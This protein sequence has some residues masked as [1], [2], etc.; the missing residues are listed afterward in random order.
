MIFSVFSF[1][2]EGTETF[3]D[4]EESFETRL[5]V[6]KR[7][8][9]A[10]RL[11]DDSR[12]TVRE[13][14][15]SYLL[16]D[17][18]CEGK[19]L[20]ENKGAVIETLSNRNYVSLQ[21][22][23]FDT[24]SG[25]PE[26]PEEMEIEEYPSDERGYY[27]LQFIGPIKDE[28]K[29][30][31]EDTGVDLHGFRHRFNFIVEMDSE[32]KR[33]A[34][35]L[36]FVNWIGIYQPAYRIDQELLKRSGRLELEVHTFEGVNLMRAGDKIADLGADIHLI[37]KNKISLEIESEKI[38]DLA[39]LP[40]VKSIREEVKDYRL[41][42][43][44]TTWITQTNE[45]D[46]RKVT[47]EGV[48]GEGELITVMDSELYMENSGHQMW[49][50]PD[51]NEV[52][53]EHR[54]VQGFYVPTGSDADLGEGEYHGTHVTGSVLGDAYLY[55]E[56]DENDG[57][58]IGARLIFQDIGTENEEL[59]LPPDM[60]ADAYG[61]SYEEGSRVHT[62]S[63]GGESGY[64]D[65]AATADEFIWNNKNFTIL[66]AMGNEGDEENSLTAQAEGKN[67]ISV[68]GA[69]NAPDQ[70][71]VAEFSG[72]GYADDGRIKPTLL[73]IGQWVTSAGRSKDG[74]KTLSGTSS[75]TPGI[76]GQVGQIRQ[77][78]S[79]G[80]YP[81]GSP[82]TEDGFNP[83]N[84]LV[85]ATLINGAVEISGNGAYEN[86][87]RFP[88]NDQGFGRS[89]LD[90]ALHFEGD[91]RGLEVFDSWNENLELKTG[92]SWETDLHVDDP[93]QELEITLVWSDYPG[94]GDNGPLTPFEDDPAIVNDLDLEV[95][96]PDGTRYAGNAFTGF[97]PGYSEPDPN[98]NPWNGLRD[99]EYDGLNVE[100][101]LLLLPDENGVEI[102][103]YEINVTAH[104]IPE[105]N[106]PFALVVSG[107]MTGQG[108]FSPTKPSPEDGETGVSTDVNLSVH[109][110]HTEDEIMDVRFYNAND[111]EL[112]GERN[113]VE[114][115]ERT[116]VKWTDLETA[117]TYQWYAVAE[118][119][120]GNT[121]KSKTWKFMTEIVDQP[122]FLVNVTSPEDGSEFTESEMINVEYKVE[123]IGDTEGEQDIRFTVH[124]EVTDEKIYED[125]YDDLYLESEETQTGNFTWNPGE[126]GGGEYELRVESENTSDSITITTVKELVDFFEVEIT[127]P[128][129]GD[130]FEKGDEVTV[131]FS[132]TNTGDK[133]G[134]QTIVF[135]VDGDEVDTVEM[136]IEVNET[137]KEEFIW[138]AEESGEFDLKV[139][140]EDDEDAITVTVE[141][142]GGYI[143]DEILEI[144]GFTTTILLFS[145]V[146]AVAIYQKK[147]EER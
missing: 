136:T 119:L 101:N 130:K 100:E 66:Y 52:G 120:D 17:T 70:E 26:V 48:T 146:L 25:V 18:T 8:I 106:Q 82:A 32:T 131:E 141:G 135:T 15:D 88:N 35:D 33:D 45:T 2:G 4:E 91:E 29:E 49:E 37:G 13:E 81:T 54:K 99:E 112:I 31:L 42:N 63:W 115:E 80:W 16:L 11:Q 6:R 114:S 85:R 10:I 147:V 56:Y 110:E 28:W 86:D 24:E 105:G 122:Y 44:D 30:Q 23:S 51:G 145:M 134:T 92:E 43:D 60:Y 62:N 19:E 121:A 53:D 139:A 71:E 59:S 47:E 108:P 9:D 1:V 22:Y 68:G 143:I 36:H 38:D 129:D 87:A 132:I 95:T 83:S 117:M 97:N 140:S 128:Y 137:E 61:R 116:E 39:N 64:G 78:Y 20:L 73:H 89:K 74:Y 69:I 125:I 65:D 40:G 104:N 133:E 144:P 75:A 55:D 127:S 138:T 5:L 96:A 72:R 118:D 3:E 46:N 7:G 21:S 124:E 12:Y 14:Y 50:D 76:A 107:G 94:E 27:I 98:S 93:D 123:N 79:D 111:D 102:G 126:K 77:Y 58:A 34:E 57:N 90:R 113:D 142:E 41:F 67:V 103:T 109:V 84:A